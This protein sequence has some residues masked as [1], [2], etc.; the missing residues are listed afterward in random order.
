MSDPSRTFS[1]KCSFGRIHLKFE[2]VGH[3]GQ[4]R[5]GQ[6]VVLDDGDMHPAVGP[7]ERV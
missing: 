1:A 6:R 2:P 4:R 5:M 3:V 7:T